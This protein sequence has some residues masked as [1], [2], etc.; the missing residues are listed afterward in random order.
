ML[1]Y[2]HV[3]QWLKTGFGLVIKFLNHLQAVTTNDCKTVT[4][5]HTTKYSTL[6]SSVYLHYS[7]RIYNTGTM[8]VS[9][10]HTLSISLCYCTHKVFKSQIKSSQASFLYS[11]V[12][13]KLAVLSSLPLYSGHLLTYSLT[14]CPLL[15]NLLTYEDAARTSLR[16]NICHLMLCIVVW[17]HRAFASCADKKKTQLPLLLC[18]CISGMA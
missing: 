1:K 16:E 10:N 11:F 15:R 4:D 5:F 7:S 18:A 3:Y 9:L 8:K 17:R 14:H 13:L 12:I 2:C 6:I